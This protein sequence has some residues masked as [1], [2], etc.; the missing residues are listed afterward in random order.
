[1]NIAMLTDRLALGGG[2]ECIRLL[3]AHLP[4]HRF[5]VFAAGGGTLPALESLPNV[6]TVR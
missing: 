6:R 1:M 5:T 3:A 2:P 4:Q